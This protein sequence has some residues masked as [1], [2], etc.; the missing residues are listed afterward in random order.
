MLTVLFVGAGLL[1][2]L[3]LVI[4][5]LKAIKDFLEGLSGWA[6]V[7]I[8]AVGGALL[9]ASQS[10]PVAPAVPLSAATAASELAPRATETVVA[11]RAPAAATAKAAPGRTTTAPARQAPVAQQ[12][13]PVATQAPLEVA[14]EASSAARWREWPSST[15]A[16]IAQP[17]R[18]VPV[19]E[20]PAYEAPAY[21]APGPLPVLDMSREV[22]V[23]GYHRKDGT[24]VREHTRS[25]PGHGH[26]GRR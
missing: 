26:R 22:H 16:P 11:V 17:V 19:Y 1:V 13:R 25:A 21:I 5:I 3:L 7:G 2:G 9:W 10:H 14:D 15:S 18:A 24:Y 20:M 23:G 4:G 12:P 8:F 6:W